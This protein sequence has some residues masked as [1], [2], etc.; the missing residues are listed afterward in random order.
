MAHFATTFEVSPR[1]KII[2]SPSAK[3]ASEPYTT[4]IS[5]DPMP[6]ED[7]DVIDHEEEK[8]QD[9]EGFHSD[10]SS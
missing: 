9:D 6:E 10:V 1:S 5:D 8:Y 7:D 4:I 2:P 3:R